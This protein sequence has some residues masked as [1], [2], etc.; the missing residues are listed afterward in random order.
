MLGLILLAIANRDL[1]RAAS[2]YH[3][4]A[5]ECLKV[6]HYWP[7]QHFAGLIHTLVNKIEYA[8]GIA[9]HGFVVN[10]DRPKKT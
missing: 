9:M 2:W 10:A 4:F 8:V 5:Y 3:R 6:S 7:P 1:A